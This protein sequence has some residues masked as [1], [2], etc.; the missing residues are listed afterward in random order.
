MSKIKIKPQ[1]VKT[2]LSKRNIEEKSRGGNCQQYPAFS[3][4]HLTN[5]KK[6]T[7]G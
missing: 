6:Y 5:N 4:L 2:K 1:E 7:I 3:F